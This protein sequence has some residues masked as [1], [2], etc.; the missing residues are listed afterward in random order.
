MDRTESFRRKMPRSKPRVEFQYL[1][2]EIYIDHPEALGCSCDQSTS[3]VI[4]ERSDVTFGK[5]RLVW[6]NQVT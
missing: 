1:W 2:M 3:Q 5:N 4:F 6:M